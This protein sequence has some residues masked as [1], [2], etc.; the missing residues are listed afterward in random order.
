MW[1][2][3]TEGNCV[4]T[5]FEP[6]CKSAPIAPSLSCRRQDLKFGSRSGPLAFRGKHYI[7]PIQIRILNILLPRRT[8]TQYL[9]GFG[10]TH[11]KVPIWTS[12]Y[13]SRIKRSMVVVPRPACLAEIVSDTQWFVKS[14]PVFIYPSTFPSSAVTVML[15]TLIPLLGTCVP[16]SHR[17][18]ANITTPKWFHYYWLLLCEVW[19]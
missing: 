9:S 11:F 1:R 8:L 14:S 2:I 10:V 7:K 12:Y 4:L 5:I 15:T 19:A 3:K 17:I 16:L 6:C 18:V 13:S